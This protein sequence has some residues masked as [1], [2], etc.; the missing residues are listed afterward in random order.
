MPKEKKDMESWREWMEQAV[1]LAEQAG[2]EVYPNPRVGALYWRDGQVLGRGFHRKAGE[3][4]AELDAARAAGNLKGSTLVVTLEPCTVRGKTP[5]CTDFIIAQGISRVVYGCSDPTLKAESRAVLEPHGIEVLGPLVVPGASRLLEIFLKNHL[6]GKTHISLKWAMSSDGHTATSGG[7]SHW[8]TGEKARAHAHGLRRKVDGIMVGAGTVLTD[9]P[10]LDLRHGV[11]GRAPRPVIWDP[12]ARTR[13][14]RDWWS[15]MS[16][17]RP[18][19]FSREPSGWP[20]GVSV[21]DGGI[22][23]LEKRLYA[24]GIH[25]LLVEGGAGLHGLLCDHAL[26][27]RLYVYVAPTLLGGESAPAAV[28]GQGMAKLADARRFLWEPPC[29]LGEDVLLSAS[30]SEVGGCV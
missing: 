15:K 20:A 6:Q 12:N 22:Q 24:E 10:G 28:A 21:L 26:G 16:G 9:L 4:H 5:A 1:Q 13:G 25:A 11:V 27:D 17:R 2:S 19:V 30:L 8:I 18:M 7:E 14:L 29:L 23:Q 3:E